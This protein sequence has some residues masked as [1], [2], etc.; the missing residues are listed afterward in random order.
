MVSQRSRDRF[1]AKYGPWSVVTGASSGIGRETAVLLA[2]YGSNLVLVARG[3]AR[4]RELA[5]ELENRHGIAV[6][7]VAADLATDDGVRAVSDSTRDL[8]VGLLVAAAGYGVSGPFLAT[9]LDQHLDLVDVNCRAAVALAWEFGKRFSARGRGGVVLYGSIVGFQGVPWAAHYA[10]TKAYIQTFAEG[11]AREVAPSGVDV[12][13]VAPGPTQTGFAD[14]ASMK[15]DGAMSPRTVASATLKALGRHT[16]IHPG[17]MTKVLTYSLATLPRWAKV[18]IMGQV[19]HGMAKPNSAA[20]ATT[21][22]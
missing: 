18:R 2:E 21:G 7:V 17:L 10:A 16:T 20:P 13:S 19:M 22:V 15:M 9:P 4:L 5:G 11:F 14:R 8:D 3:E 6:R 12:L 1:L